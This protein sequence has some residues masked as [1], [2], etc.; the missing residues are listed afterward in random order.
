MLK[1]GEKVMTG[2]IEKRGENTYRLVVSGGK[3]P[4][5]TSCKKTKNYTWHS[6]RC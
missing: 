1:G 4:D 6:K 5:G 2:S 3:N